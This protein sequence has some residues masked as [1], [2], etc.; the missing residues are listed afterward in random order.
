MKKVVVCRIVDTAPYKTEDRERPQ[1]NALALF[2]PK[3]PTK[4]F[5]EYAEDVEPMPA[6]SVLQ[7][8]VDRAYG[9]R[10]GKTV[11][12]GQVLNVAV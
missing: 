4:A 3:V 9:V 1:C 7:S 12:I 8:I 6:M 2:K 11:R 10:S 5:D